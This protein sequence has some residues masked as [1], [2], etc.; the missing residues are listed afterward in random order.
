[1]QQPIAIPLGQPQIIQSNALSNP[2]NPVPVFILQPLPIPTDQQVYVI[3]SQPHPIMLTSA[4]PS[5]Y[6]QTLSP[7]NLNLPA[8]SSPCILPLQQQP[9]FLQATSSNFA[10]MIP[11]PIYQS[12]AVQ[13]LP[14][15]A[16]AGYA[17]FMQMSTQQ[18]ENV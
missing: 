3:Q 8:G 4:A 7:I 14:L 1:M 6:Q 5:G 15:P 13:T 16:N 18:N 17:Q 10:S 11:Q 2:G 9:V 12:N